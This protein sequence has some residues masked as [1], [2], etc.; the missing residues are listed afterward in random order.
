MRDLNWKIKVSDLLNNPWQTDILNFKK[1]FLKENLDIQNEWISGECTLTWLSHNEILVELKNIKFTIRYTCDICWEYYEQNFIIKNK[2][3]IT[4]TDNI[5][6]TENIY[7]DIFKIDKKKWLID[8]E[9]IIWI[10]I[11]NKEPIIKKCWKCKNKIKSKLEKNQDEKLTYTIDFNKMF[12][13]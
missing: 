13:S 6:N 1:K 12:K 11:K 10:I 4:F 9:D 8:L 5:D 2:E 7:D 3:K